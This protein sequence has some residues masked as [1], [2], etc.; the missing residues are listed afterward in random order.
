MTKSRLRKRRDARKLANRIVEQSKSIGQYEN[1]TNK[2]LYEHILQG[3]YG[4]G[5]ED[6]TAA[7]TRELAHKYEREYRDNDP[8]VR[9]LRVVTRRTP[10]PDYRKPLTI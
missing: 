4:H 3:D 1:P 5:W 2:Y 7:E 10:N 9:G 6:V 8:H